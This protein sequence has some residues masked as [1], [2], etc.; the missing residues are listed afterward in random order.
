MTY[1]L[2][3]K[4]INGVLVATDSLE[5]QLGAFARWDDYAPILTTKGLTE[6]DTSTSL[7]PAE[8]T[9][10]FK[11]ERIKNKKG[12]QKL[13]NLTKNSVL[14]TAGLADINNKSILD[15]CVSIEQQLSAL[16]QPPTHSQIDNIVFTTINTELTADPRPQSEKECCHHILCVREQGVNYI[17]SLCYRENINTSVKQYSSVEDSLAR[18]WIYMAGSIGM[19]KGGNEINKFSTIYLPTPQQALKIA[20]NLMSLSILTEELLYEIPGVGGDIYCGLLTDSGFKFIGSETDALNTLL[21]L[22]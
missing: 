13:F 5:L 10:I 7:T 1:I 9:N 2:A 8:I 3:I 20:N 21:N 6:T 4:T 15:I 16:P 14:L 12:A 18:R 17:Y 19:A 22:K 11:L